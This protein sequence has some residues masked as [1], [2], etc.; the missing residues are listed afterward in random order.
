MSNVIE[1]HKQFREVAN[2]VMSP[3][4]RKR[5]YATQR[6]ALRRLADRDFPNSLP[7]QSRTGIV[8]KI[9]LNLEKEPDD[10]DLRR[11]LKSEI[12]GLERV[13][14]DGGRYVPEHHGF[15]A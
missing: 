8:C 2:L 12:D 3:S 7:V 6:T 9:L 1:S 10:L 13:I 11:A 15:N 14:A 5:I 4:L